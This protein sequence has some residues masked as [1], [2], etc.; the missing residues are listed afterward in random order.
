[1]TSMVMIK[2][3]INMKTKIMIKN[4]MKLNGETMIVTDMKLLVNIEIKRAVENNVK[5]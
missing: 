3:K 2:I 1:M 5:K 4:T